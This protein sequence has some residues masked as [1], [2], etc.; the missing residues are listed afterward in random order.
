MRALVSAF[1]IALLALSCA[2]AATVAA[3]ADDVRAVDVAHSKA[4]FA[5]QH[6]YVARVT[7]DVPIVSG[8]VTM[9]GDSLVPLAVE[10]TL[11]ARKIKTGDDDRDS[12]IQ[13]TDW[14]DTKHFPTWTYRST[15]IVAGANGTFVVEG[16]LTV[17]GVAAPVTL[18]A[19]AKGLPA[20]PAFRAVG[21]VDRHA[22]H[23]AI[24]RTDALVASDVEIVLTIVLK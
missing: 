8:T 10:A 9:P 1:R 17:H 3:R 7:G 20:S 2:A 19:T 5:V 13:G 4:A 14:F 11:D 6:L 24:T 22:F 23:M 15:K 21:H 12:D 16:L 18:T